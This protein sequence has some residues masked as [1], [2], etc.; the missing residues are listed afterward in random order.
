[1]KVTFRGLGALIPV[2]LGLSFIAVVLDGHLRDHQ[3]RLGA[4]GIGVGAL[5]LVLG[6]VL[7]RKRPRGVDAHHVLLHIPIEYWGGALLVAGSV[8][9]GLDV[10]GLV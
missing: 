10:A 7:N 2:L 1:M 3:W 9:V 5:H 8:F 4:I 6:L